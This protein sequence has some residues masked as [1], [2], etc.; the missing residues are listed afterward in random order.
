MTVFYEKRNPP[1]TTPIVYFKLVIVVIKKRDYGRIKYL[2][3][4]GLKYGLKKPN[5]IKTYLSQQG[6]DGVSLDEIIELMV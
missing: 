6:F 2:I 3:K 1:Q 4:N 5:D